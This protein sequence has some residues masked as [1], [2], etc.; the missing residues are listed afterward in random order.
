MKNMSTQTQHTPGPWNRGYG[1]FVYQGERVA[2]EQRL[3]AVCEPTT[4]TREDW[5][6][7]FANAQLIAAAPEL[8]QALQELQKE[9][10]AVVR[11]DVKKHF[12]LMLAD[13]AA[14]KAIAKA[15][16]QL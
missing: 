3:V 4:K 15:T 9:M 14:S 5:E 11:L 2:P 16:G 1:N 7:V 6:Q 12:S 10:R 13:A 8:L